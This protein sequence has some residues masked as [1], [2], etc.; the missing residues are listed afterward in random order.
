MCMA[1]PANTSTAVW[2][3]GEPQMRDVVVE[4]LRA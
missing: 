4:G 2:Y 3:S 1:P